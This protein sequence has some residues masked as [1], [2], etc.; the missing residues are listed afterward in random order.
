MCNSVDWDTLLIRD[1]VV[2]WQGQRMDSRLHREHPSEAPLVLERNTRGH[3]KE[4]LGGK[5]RTQSE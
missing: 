2:H 1:S 3:W 5:D 4:M